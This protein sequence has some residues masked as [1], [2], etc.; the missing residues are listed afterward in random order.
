[1]S[2]LK[3]G[4]CADIEFLTKPFFGGKPHRINANVYRVGFKKP[5]LSIRGEWNGVMTA[6]PLTGDEFVFVDVKQ[7]TE[8]KKVVS[9]SFLESSLPVLF[10]LK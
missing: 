2:C 4:Y 10:Y 7:K 1:M 8:S 3:T 6:K 5:I 9:L